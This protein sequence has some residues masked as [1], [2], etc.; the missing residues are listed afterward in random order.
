MAFFW[1]CSV[2]QSVD[3]RCLRM[4]S[5]AIELIASNNALLLIQL[6][7]SIQHCVLRRQFLLMANMCINKQEKEAE[8]SLYWY[9]A[10]NRTASTPD[11]SRK[12]VCSKTIWLWWPEVIYAVQTGTTSERE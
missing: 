10:G 3:G 8:L 9:F 5:I 2:E 4:F 7:Y 11:W 6:V 12:G 1:S